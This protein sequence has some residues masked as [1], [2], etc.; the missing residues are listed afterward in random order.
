MTADILGQLLLVVVGFLI[1]LGGWAGALGIFVL[2]QNRLWRREDRRKH[3]VKKRTGEVHLMHYRC[4]RCGLERSAW[5]D[6]PTP[7]REDGH[8][9]EFTNYPTEGQTD[10]GS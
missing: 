6:E 3:D 8:Y 7:Y 2:V 9:W 5:S 1:V 10:G 4:G